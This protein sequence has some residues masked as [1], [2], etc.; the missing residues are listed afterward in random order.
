MK[1][2][3]TPITLKLS[4]EENILLKHLRN[5]KL[6]SVKFRRKQPIGKYVVDFVSFEIK[7]I[8]ELDGSQHFESENDKTRDNWLKNQGFIILRFWNN[9]VKQNL[10]DILNNI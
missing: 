2:N 6:N 1:S 5:F 4:T 7:L 9:Q 8:V 3:L 10:N